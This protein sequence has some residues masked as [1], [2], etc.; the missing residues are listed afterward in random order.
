MFSPVLQF[1]AIW[2]GLLRVWGVSLGEEVRHRLVGRF[3]EVQIEVVR[4]RNDI[5]FAVPLDGI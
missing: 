2:F 5:L 4:L 3:E 1:D